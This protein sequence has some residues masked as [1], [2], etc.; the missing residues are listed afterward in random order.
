M[1]RYEIFKKMTKDNSMERL[2]YEIRPFLLY[3]LGFLSGQ[4]DHPIKWVSVVLFI[5]TSIFIIQ[6]RY[7]NRGR[8]LH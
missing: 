4:L 5:L 1:G 2:L 6:M 7:V 3:A 8:K